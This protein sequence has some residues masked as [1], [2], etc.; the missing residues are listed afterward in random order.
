MNRESEDLPGNMGLINRVDGAFPVKNS[1]D[2][3]R[4]IPD[5]VFRSGIFLEKYYDRENSNDC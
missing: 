5:L 3:K 1:E 2:K 4:D